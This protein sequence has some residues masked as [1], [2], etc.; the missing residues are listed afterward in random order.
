MIKSK[1]SY[2]K[3][4][5]KKQKQINKNAQQ[6]QKKNIKNKKINKNKVYHKERQ[7]E[8][9]RRSSLWVKILIQRSPFPRGYF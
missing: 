2:E 7:D 3:K 9:F 8:L 1:N 6:L 5:T 4:T